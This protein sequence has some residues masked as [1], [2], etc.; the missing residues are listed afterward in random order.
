MPHKLGRI[1]L[2]FTTLALIS[3]SSPVGI[4]PERTGEALKPPGS[5]EPQSVEELVS[6]SDAVVIAEVSDMRSGRS[7]GDYGELEFV[8]SELIVRE[9]LKGGSVGSTYIVEIEKWGHPYTNPWQISDEVL[10]FLT[11]KNE[12]VDAEYYRPS[13]PWAM[14]IVDGDELLPTVPGDH[15]TVAGEE[16]DAMS[17][18]EIVEIIRE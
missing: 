16:I 5:V 2:C 7:M 17:T 11:R 8:E 18:H 12:T 1:G 6:A 3:C 14:F 15:T 9:V 4:E 10:A 13:N